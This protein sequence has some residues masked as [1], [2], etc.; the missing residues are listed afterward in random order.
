[1]AFLAR[2]PAL[3]EPGKE[4]KR[5][6][7]SHGHDR[8]PWSWVLGSQLLSFHN[9]VARLV[10]TAVFLPAMQA[11]ICKLGY[12]VHRDVPLLNVLVLRY[13]G[14]RVADDAALSGG[15]RVSQK[16]TPCFPIRI[17]HAASLLL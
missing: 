9:T 13:V 6:E 3:A 5:Q 16:R 1:M 2:T 17:T 11:V 8:L 7:R 4:Q 12:I 10:F 14:W 15:Q